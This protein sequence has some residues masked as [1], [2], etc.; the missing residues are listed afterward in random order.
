MLGLARDLDSA[1]RSPAKAGPVPD[2]PKAIVHEFGVFDL[3]CYTRVPV[4]PSSA[5]GTS[6]IF[7]VVPHPFEL[8]KICC[9]SST[10]EYRSMKARQRFEVLGHR[11]QCVGKQTLFF[12]NYELVRANS[13]DFLEGVYGPGGVQDLLEMLETR[14]WDSM[15]MDRI[16]HFF[17]VDPNALSVA[18]ADWLFQYF[19]FMFEFRQAIWARTHWFYLPASE[20]DEK[21]KRKRGSHVEPAPARNVDPRL[22]ELQRRRRS[23][24]NALMTAYVQLMHDAPAGMDALI[25]S[26]PA[27]WNLP[28]RPCPW[29]LT[30]S[31]VVGGASMDRQL[32][33]V[34]QLEPIR[35]FFASAPAR[36][37]EALIPEQLPLLH[38]HQG[39]C[40]E[41]PDPWSRVD[42]APLS[43]NEATDGTPGPSF[44]RSGAAF[45]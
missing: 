44:D 4:C 21:K 30:D 9:R 6:H 2:V 38:E 39:Q 20:S 36:F 41:V 32:R 11:T 27:L 15:W 43:Y 1:T 13:N 3:A 28:A 26:E 29:L 23:L 5:M 35:T 12:P 40:F 25:L 10:V 34:D 8:G 17:L 22:S 42:Y 33:E 19:K 37:V 24:D 16:R 31:Q 14:P 18:Q 45:I 7:R